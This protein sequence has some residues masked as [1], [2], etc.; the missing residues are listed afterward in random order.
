[1]SEPNRKYV[2]EILR[3]LARGQTDGY[4]GQDPTDTAG[5]SP[6]AM[7]RMQQELEA[8]GFG[9]DQASLALRM[10]S[11]SGL[12][13]RNWLCLNVPEEDL[14]SAFDPGK[15]SMI[16]DVQTFSDDKTNAVME[17]PEEASS[18]S[19]VLGTGSTGTEVRV[20]ALI[21]SAAATKRAEPVP[22]NALEKALV[23]SGFAL[24]ACRAALSE[25]KGQM[26]AALRKLYSDAMLA[27]YAENV[28]DEGVD[29]GNVDNSNSD[30]SDDEDLVADEVSVLASM[31]PDTPVAGPEPDQVRGGHCV[32]MTL[33]AEVGL[34]IQG[35]PTELELWL[36]AGSKYPRR[37]S[38]REC[39]A[40]GTGDGTPCVVL[41]R[42]PAFD[43]PTRRRVTR[44]VSKRVARMCFEM[45]GPVLY[46]VA[47]FCQDELRR[48]VA[49]PNDEPQDGGGSGKGATRAE[50]NKHDNKHGRQLSAGPS[51]DHT[52]QTS[53]SSQPS[54]AGASTG[55]PGDASKGRHDRRGRGGPRPH[56]TVIASP[57]A[58]A[59]LSKRLQVQMAQRAE[60]EKTDATFSLLQKGRRKLPSAQASE[61]IVRA[62]CNNRVVL[63]AGETGCGK[64]TQV[65]QFVL[66]D[67][68]RRGKGGECNI[69]CTQPRRIAA[70]G[71]AERV[72]AEQG[73]NLGS[74]VGYQ[75]RLD[76][77]MSQD[78]RLLFCTTGILLRRMHGDPDL[79]GVTVSEVSNRCHLPH[80]QHALT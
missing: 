2:E 46:D 20:G 60:L 65:P 28:E 24:S 16:S 9:S 51:G 8:L 7:A 10:R 30:D 43:G 77:K 62:I 69:V 61:Q 38:R 18:S 5:T 27:G 47:Q 25:C 35:R 68:V 17:N 66:D 41:V 36:P 71:V 54:S 45:G 1:M 39:T 72:A 12:E 33:G 73:V 15:T 23:E 57:A 67:A 11:G 70:I 55:T 19:A 80:A 44:E 49:T 76:K 31:F 42:N 22:S 75:I 78:T 53:A 34:M 40:G 13:A 79:R 56:I 74:T 14:P 32:R 59:E 48:I 21:S 6:E 37:C 52:V 29:G 64:T 50:T 26:A 3:S 58:R 63:V 4:I